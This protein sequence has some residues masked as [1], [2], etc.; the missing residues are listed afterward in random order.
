[1]YALVFM[2]EWFMDG[3]LSAFMSTCRN[4]CVFVC[5]RKVFIYILHQ[6][7]SERVHFLFSGKS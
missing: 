4:V 5:G 1:M 7:T 6:F 2:Y 3:L